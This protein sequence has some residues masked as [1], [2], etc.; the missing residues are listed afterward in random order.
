MPMTLVMPKPTAQRSFSVLE[1]SFALGIVA[2]VVV[3]VL[4]A[5]GSGGRSRT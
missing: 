3:F 5:L 2:L 4:P 1:W